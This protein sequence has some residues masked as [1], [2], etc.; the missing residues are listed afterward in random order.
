MVLAAGLTS[1]REPA[2]FSRRLVQLALDGKLALVMTET[3]LDEAAAVLVDPGFTARVSDEEA[4]VLMAGLVASASI[5]LT[6]RG[7]S[8]PRRCADPEDDYLVDAA[9]S[10]DAFLVSRD[11]RADFASVEHLASG[12]P[13]TALRRFGFFDE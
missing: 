5:F 6:D 10:T 1:R 4:A 11:D 9:L 12:K 2:S 8:A 3:L 7:T 13:G